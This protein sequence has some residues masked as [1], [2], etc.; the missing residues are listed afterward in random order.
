MLCFYFN[1]LKSQPATFSALILF[2]KLAVNYLNASNVI[3]LQL[4]KLMYVEL[5]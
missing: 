2:V 3:F 1:L 5:D 4:V